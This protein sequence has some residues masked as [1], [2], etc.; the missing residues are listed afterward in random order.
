MEIKSDYKNSDP[1]SAS[2]PGVNLSCDGGWDS[3]D[4]IVEE[5]DEF[6]DNDD[7]YGIINVNMK[8][9]MIRYILFAML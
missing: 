4:D 6:V 9:T 5:S 2:P 7:K 3:E 8:V 1:S